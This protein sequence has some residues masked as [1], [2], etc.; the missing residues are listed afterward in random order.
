MSSSYNGL[1]KFNY[2]MAGTF[3]GEIISYGDECWRQ[4][5][6]IALRNPDRS[7][8]YFPLLLLA[9]TVVMIVIIESHKNK[10]NEENEENKEDQT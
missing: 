2:L 4:Y 9:I 7:G 10:E 3:V 6:G 5:K 8:L 1:V